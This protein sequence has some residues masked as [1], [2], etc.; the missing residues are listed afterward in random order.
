VQHGLGQRAD[1]R[2]HINTRDGF[3]GVA[4]DAK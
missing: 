2:A 1:A 4:A 3:V